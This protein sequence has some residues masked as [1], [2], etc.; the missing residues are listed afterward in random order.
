MASTR[1]RATALTWLALGAPLNAA[2]QEQGEILHVFTGGGSAGQGLGHAIN[3][4]GDVNADGFDDVVV[5][6]RN[7]VNSKAGTARV[8][9]GADGAVLYTFTGNMPA[10]FFG[11]TVDGAGDVNADGYADLVVGAVGE[12]ANGIDSGAAYVLSGRDGSQLH[13]F[14]GAFAKARFGGSVSGA[15]DVNGDGFDDVI[16][17]GQP[18]TAPGHAR[19]LSGADGAVLYDFTGASVTSRLGCAVD[20]AGDVDGDGVGDLVVGDWRDPTAATG[21]G[22]VSVFSGAN[23]ALLFRRYGDKANDRLGLAVSGVGDAN[24]DGLSEFMAGTGW[25]D[26]A[27]ADVGMARVYSGADGATLYTLYGEAMFDFFGAAAAGVGDFDADGAADFAV[28]AYGDDDGGTNSGS[29]RV[30]SGAD[31]TEIFRID[32][33]SP[34]DELGFSV[35]AAGSV[36]G[37]GSMDL[38]LGAPVDNQGGGSGSGAAYVIAGA[39]PA[40]SVSIYCASG[41]NAY[42]PGAAIGYLGTTSVAA[43][44]FVLTVAGAKPRSVGLFFFGAQQQQQPFMKGFLCVGGRLYRAGPPIHLDRTGAA[45]LALA[46]GAR[47]W[48]RSLLVA[49]ST[50]NFQFVYLDTPAR[51]GGPLNLSDALSAAFVP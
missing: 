11:Q 21:G 9:S 28:G 1:R 2:A 51:T 8:H 27:I 20:L 34:A 42:G 39:E 36:S 46:A 43:K 7:G 44:D 10:A 33:D 38:A 19:V 12:D 18:D 3:P 29:V 47:P 37:T 49:G 26:K 6:F 50:W 14:V 17:G 23:G 22:S 25:A 31:G 41:P 32:G 4:A 24:G 40:G 45:E 16:A 5:G 48:D 13:R 30:Y 15:G 35:S